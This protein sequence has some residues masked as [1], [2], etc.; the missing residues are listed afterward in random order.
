VS[1]PDVA[2]FERVRG[3]LEAIAYG[4][5]GDAGEAEDVAQDAWLRWQAADRSEV[6]EPE[7]FLVTVVTRLS[8]DRLRSARAR[9]EAYVGP[10]LPEPWAIR[11]LHGSAPPDPQ[12]VAATAESL[13]LALLATLERLNPVERAVLLLRDV[14]DLEYAEVADAVGRTPATC[15]QLARR[16]RE[17]AGDPRSRFT[18][19]PEEESRLAE[20][21]AA[22]ADAGSLEGLVE[23]LAADAVS[24]SDGGG[25]VK[26]ARKPVHGRERIARL[27]VNLRV[28]LAPPGTTI[29][30]VRVN[31]RPGIRVDTPDGLFSVT[32]LEVADGR[33]VGLHSVNNPAKLVRLRAAEDGPGT[34]DEVLPRPHFRERHERRIAAPPAAV[35]AALQALRAQDIPVARALMA[36][37][38]LPA[39]LTGAPRQA[40]AGGPFL[41]S[42]PVPLLAA[43]PGRR[44]LLGGV[45]QPWRLRGGPAP[46][47]LDAAGLAAFAEPGWVKT[48][49]DLVL[50]PDGDGTRL[51]TETRIEAT[52]RR[53]RL[54]FGAYWIV[55]RAGSGVIRHELLRQ[56]E[57]RARSG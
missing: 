20:A 42:A 57:R 26:A 13:S 12:D 43:D 40:T 33:I 24:W 27:L 16:A 47:A 5:L 38:G 28:R 50:V 10:W 53:S 37:R 49:M 52:D 56:V 11:P 31:G 14:F 48:A 1:A 23:L 25:A 45:M 18:A 17:R 34:L 7:A 19:A 4:M 2:A 21:F 54:R 39:R 35:W 22:A 51:L 55:V 44:V 6:R 46:P 3:R 36:L 15:R 8:L 32:A 41:T 29:R 9:R 30:G